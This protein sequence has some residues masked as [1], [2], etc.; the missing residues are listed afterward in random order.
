MARLRLERHY[1]ADRP[2]PDRLLDVVR[3]LIGVQ[4]QVMSSAELALSA[5]VEG[6]RPDDVRDALW[7]RRTLVKTWAMRG[8]LHLV[9]SDELPELVGALANR[10]SWRSPVWLRYFGVTLQQMEELLDAFGEVL[11]ATPATKA[12]VADAIATR[13]GDPELGAKLRS[14]WGTFLKPAAM[15]GLLVYGPDDG[16]N[17]TY[18]DPREWLGVSMPAP[19]EASL[20]ALL[21]RYLALQPGTS[22]DQLARWLGVARATIRRGLR[23]IES[24]MVV[25]EVDG[26]RTFVRHEDLDCLTSDDPPANALVRLVGG[27]DPYVFA[28]TRA[29]PPLLPVERRHLVSRT[30]GWISPSLL[31]DGAI[32]GTWS[33]EVRTERLAVDLT[34]WR[35]LSAGERRSVAEEADRIGRFLDRPVD[36]DIAAVLP[37]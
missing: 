7:T 16:R 21:R 25:V 8:T 24:G 19:S 10:R 3:D 26:E 29:A 32:V 13:T 23:H 12:A 34:P 22:L 35:R 9:A 18:V 17:V 11:G 6:L 4:A 15:N 2:T 27:F 30:A 1:L 14:G 33:H 37:A 5:R 31:I 36:L 28:L 20:G